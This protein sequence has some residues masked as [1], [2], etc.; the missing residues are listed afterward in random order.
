M[1]DPDL[2]RQT[3]LDRLLPGDGFSPELPKALQPR[4]KRGA[5][6]GLGL[7]VLLYMLR[8]MRVG[9]FDVHLPNGDVRHFRGSEAGPHGVLNIRSK[10]IIGHVLKGGEVGFG[11]AYLDGC[12]DSPDLAALLG[13][14][15]LNEPHYKGPYEK[16]L[17]GRF[18]GWLKHR[19]KSNTR[20]T[21]RKNIAYHYDLGND[22]YKLWL[23]DTMAYSSAVFARRG[24]SPGGPSTGFTHEPNETL[25]DAQLNK[26][27]EMA[28][29]LKLQPHHHLLE[30]GSGWGGF[31]IYA[32]Q[33]SG[34]RVTSITLSAEQLAEA[35]KRAAA[36]GVADRVT[37]ELRDYR[38]VRETYDRVV[39]IE[40]YEAVGEEYWPGYFEMLHDALKPGGIAAI[41]GITISPKIF[42]EYR[43]KRD[44]IQKYI[45]PGGM[46]S[47]PGHFQDL[48][49]AAGLKP[50]D[51]RFFGTD[52]A[53]TLAIW[54]RNVMAARDAIVRQFDER[55][56]RMW[57]YYLAYCECGFR[58]GSI[59]LMQITL[60]RG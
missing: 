40:M 41:Q 35:Q 37:F 25:R 43:S 17:L 24:A 11:D 27:R 54:H 30:V 7:R 5:A 57:R 33:T 4:A 50:E 8:G 42:D 21:A 15:Y 46:L 6:V 39:S 38:D 16:N 18:V 1:S 34:C 28:Q 44:F 14:L 19:L 47:P 31:A 32:A 3:E 29:R 52:Y 51:A 59:D 9:S 10:R 12:W 23:D 56:L 53:D 60:R 13:V 20:K 49:I 48:A 2:P 22:F 45:F 26:F 58:V 36:A 55:F